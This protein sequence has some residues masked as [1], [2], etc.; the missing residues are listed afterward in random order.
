MLHFIKLHNRKFHLMKKLL[1]LLLLLCFYNIVSAQDFSNKGK[2][3]WITY[4]AHIN[5]TNS[6]MGI[7]ITANTD[8]AGT[9]KVGSQTINFTVTANTVTRK[10]L[11][12][13]NSG[14]APNTSVYLSQNDGIATGAAIHVVSNN[15][16]VVYAHI[17]YSARSGAT[18]LLPSNVWGR[19][20]V[21]PSYSNVGSSAGYGTISIVAADTNTTIQITPRIASSNGVR[22]AGTPYTIT[23]ANPGDVYQVQFQLNGDISGT[24]VQSVSNGTGCKK[25]AVFSSTTWSAFGCTS[26]NS[27]DNLYQQLFP[28]G[29][30]G[31]S[32]LTAP[33]KTRS[34]DIVRV[35]VTDPT[36]TVTK[37]ENGTTTTLTGLTSS[38]YYQFTTGNPTFIQANKPVSVVHY[39]TTQACQSGANIGDPEMIVIN[40]IEQTIN[41]ITVFS[42]HKN[43]VPTNQSNVNNCY[44][45][46]IIKTAAAP[47]FKINNNTPTSS[48]IPITGTA[49]SY[50][51]EDVTTMSLTNPVQNLKADSNF[52]AIAYGFGNVESY[53]YNAG[54]NVVDLTQ[55]IVI[56]NQFA[57]TT[58]QV[59][60][61]GTPLKLATKF[62]YLPTSLTWDFGNNANISPNATVGP[63]NNP[64]PDSTFVDGTSGKTIY[65]FKLST[66][67]TFTA[68]GTYPIIVTA[69]NPTSDGC[70]GNQVLTYNVQVLEKPIANFYYTH[71][72]CV[73]DAFNFYD[74]TN[75]FGRP[76]YKWAWDFGDGS[77][78]DSTKNP[79]KTYSSAGTGSYN[80]H[81][82]SITDIGC[83][84]DTT[85]TVYLSS[86]PIAKFGMSDTTCIGKQIIFT[87]SSS[88]LVGTI[89]KWYWDYGD[90]IKDTL[91]TN[92]TRIHTY[93]TAGTYTVS[94]I[95][96]SSTGCKSVA[97]TKTFIVHVNPV[98]DF[99]LPIVCLPVGAASFANNT[100]I[101]DGTVSTVTYSWNYGDGGTGNSTNGTHNYASTG[102]F[103]VKL[104]ATSQY[105]CIK[106]TTK[107]LSTIY[108]APHADFTVTPE[109]C[110]R[111]STTFTDV[112]DAGT[113]NT[114]TN[115]YW[116]RDALGSSIYVDTAQNFKYRYGVAKTYT[117]KMYFKTDKGC[118]SD[119]ATKTLVV[120]PLPTAAF[121][122]TS[123][124]CEKNDIQFTTQSVP[125][126]GN[127]TRWYWDMGNG[128]TNNFT[129]N[130][131]FNQQFATWNNYTVKHMV[132]TD[133][134]CKSDSSIKTLNI[135]PLPHVGFII[136]EVCL[137]DANAVFTDTTSIADGSQA[138]FSYNWTFNV[139]GVTPG[140]VPATSI[141]KNGVTKYFKSDNYEVK[142]KVTSSAGCIDSLKQAFTV[143]GSIPKADFIV[144][145]ETSLCSNLPVQIKNTSSVDFGWLTKLEIYWDY[146]NQPTLI[147]TDNNPTPNQIYS[148]NYNNFQQP[149]NKPFSIKLVAY[150]GGICSDPKTKIITLNAS[151]KTQFIT[152]PGICF[153]AAPRQITQATEIGG[154]T[155]ASPAFQ[156]Y[157]TGVSSTGLFN[158]AIAGVGTFPIKYLYTSNIGCQ[159]SSTQNITVWPSPEAKFGISSPVCEKN[160][161]TISDSS[162]A[163]FSNIIKW[164]YSF[165]DATSVIRNNNSDFTKTYTSGN[166]YNAS[167]I[168]TTDSGCISTPFNKTIKVNYLPIVDFT[169]PQICL[170]D[171]NGTFND[172]STIPDN[173]EALF[174]YL[175][176]FG[177]ANN[178]T[179][180]TLKNP[181]HQYTQ[182]APMGG[183]L[184][185]LKITTK[186][187]CIDSLTK[188]FSNVYPQPKA[189]FGVIPATR[190]VCIGD[191]LF[192]TDSSQGLTS[193]VN[194]WNWTFGDGSN[195][196]LQNPYRVYTDTG[197]FT[198]QLFIYN[199]QGC[200]SDTAKDVMT[201]HPYPKLNAGPDLFVLE[202]GTIQI[203]PTFYATNPS[204][205]WSTTTYPVTYLDTITIAYPKSTPPDDITYLVKL[206]GIGGCTVQDDV[207][208]KVL[209][210]PI[211]PNA[212]SPNGDGK[213][214]T[215]IIQYL[216]S[217]PGA[218][219]EVFDRNG[220]AIFNSKNYTKPW[221]G[222]YNGKPLPVGTYYYI[223]DPKNG[224]KIMSG[225]ITILR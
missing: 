209:K 12:P 20:Y 126:A 84:S 172:I 143:N 120:N 25:I 100:T 34:S 62:P 221:D 9:I 77:A 205:L 19:E 225:S 30:W 131:S 41:N 179:P 113:G 162:K 147:Y 223:I 116:N 74:S 16:V 158:P 176:D 199:N 29:A 222:Q 37:M 91:S 35:F 184:V 53:G 104:T 214:D 196:I 148:F 193:S 125:N 1:P 165:G 15:P 121:I 61:K 28:T 138:S 186:D 213:N 79:I 210:S 89:V 99:S 117:V 123:P 146:L 48:F 54:T 215:W 63:I 159:D 56:Q 134:G 161:I 57:T 55:G 64:V 39:S 72:G 92:T 76:T 124:L 153:E 107:T 6:V 88:I 46:I 166:S 202:G 183:Y 173:S 211:V 140:P 156:Y 52:I 135:R 17:I 170:P 68:T 70:S 178:T 141:I 192:F 168:V 198:V 78:L 133:K 187:N 167:L 21:V 97:A 204:F 188:P 220:N 44:L 7:Y 115:W 160:A 2:D 49:Y 217:Y 33:F 157:G 216:E 136:P 149:A 47:S 42:A 90:G 127:I 224:R 139:T 108:V 203:K 208:I 106:D 144:L 32:F 3:F 180:S 83:I 171:G 207:F 95:V 75:G 201:V 114:I 152:M 119:T 101:S 150:S 102:P 14:D 128:V 111:D 145:N 105:G 182:L 132:E 4:P 18:L 200:I 163:N 122:N 112:N 218:T 142:L 59:T 38:N 43:W 174:S 60:C 86:K 118:I 191:T 110:L 177:D 80:V 164:D 194:K 185:K 11:G 155:G 23:L 219:V 190:Q 58:S 154:V 8:A 5:T 151:P 130:A 82:T 109:T 103:N 45:N 195:S 137:S 206:T 22:Q 10:F 96:E 36:T 81:F 93:N 13:N 31:K 181:T 73:G 50:L 169:L 40:P 69:N 98:P 212:F 94:L 24:T 175:W 51:Q 65:V 129:N 87:D 197:S 189:S 67:Y 27:G 66:S 26:A 85:K 71:T